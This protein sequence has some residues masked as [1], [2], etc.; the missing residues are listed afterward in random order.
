MNFMSSRPDVVRSS[1]QRWLLSY[2]VRL[3][4]A[5]ALPMWEGFEA[6]ELAAMAENLSI[7][8]V[9]GVDGD[10]RLL[11]R[12]HGKRIAEAYGSLCQGRFLDEVLPPLYR[13]AALSTYQR[14][15]ATKLP[16]YTIADTNDRD[17]RI[18]H[19]ERLLL[20]FSH[21]GVAI[22]RIL[23][24]LETVSPAGD[25]DNRDLLTSQR[26]APAFALCTTIQP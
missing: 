4:G 5:N 1:S 17:G 9:T 3:R 7:Q 15:L 26:K 12:F 23:A 13:D 18:V 25:F 21:D 14:V 6:E 16:V 22:D 2:W 20:P 24:S 10:T 8:D 11:I 19:Y